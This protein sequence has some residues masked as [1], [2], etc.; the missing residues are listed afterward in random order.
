VPFSCFALPNKFSAVPVRRVTFSC[1]A[2]AESF[3]VVLRASGPVFK[4]CT[5]RL[6]FGG[7]AVIESR[8]QGFRS[9]TRFRRY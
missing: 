7:T 9:R 1:F 6:V 3:P 4:F 5:P 8:F 2:L